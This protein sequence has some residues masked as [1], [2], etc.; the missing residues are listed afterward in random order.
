MTLP[1]ARR[2]VRTR[3]VSGGVLV[4]LLFVPAAFPAQ[5]MR[6]PEAVALLAA[7]RT[8]A[9]TCGRLL[10]RHAGDNAAPSAAA[11]SPMPKPKRTWTRSSRG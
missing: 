7:E 11:T 8:R 1:E 10:K 9:E 6:W 3:Q 4:A 2:H 5:T